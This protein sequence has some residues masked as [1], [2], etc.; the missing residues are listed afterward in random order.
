MIHLGLDYGRISRAQK[1]S[2]DLPKI[3]EKE[4]SLKWMDF[5]FGESSITCDVSTGKTSPIYTVYPEERNFL[6]FSLH[7]SPIRQDN[8]SSHSKQVRL[9]EH[10]KRNKEM[11]KRMQEMPRV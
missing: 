1:E 3:K 5:Q 11:G 8:V 10:E 7:L 4:S 2:E 9:G 6:Y